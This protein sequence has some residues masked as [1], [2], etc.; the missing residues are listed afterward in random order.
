MQLGD[1]CLVRRSSE[2]IDSREITTKPE[3]CTFTRLTLPIMVIIAWD[4]DMRI[5]L[6]CAYLL[7]LDLKDNDLRWLGKVGER[8][9]SEGGKIS[10]IASPQRNSAR[11]D[12]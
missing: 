7:R 4:P 3:P 11:R 5:A 1:G 8:G 9:F 10:L 2:F 6:I 12:L